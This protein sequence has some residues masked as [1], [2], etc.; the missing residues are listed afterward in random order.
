MWQRV[1][2]NE[3]LKRKKANPFEIEMKVMQIAGD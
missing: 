1:A 2:L 3:M